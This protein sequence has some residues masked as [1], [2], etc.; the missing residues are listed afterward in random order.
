MSS[1]GIHSLD[2]ENELESNTSSDGNN[3][4]DDR[5]DSSDDGKGSGSFETEDESEAPHEIMTEDKYDDEERPPVS[6]ATETPIFFH[7]DELACLERETLVAE[8]ETEI[9]R[10]EIRL[11]R[12]VGC[13]FASVCIGIAVLIVLYVVNPL[14]ENQP[15]SQAS[16]NLDVSTPTV[17][18]ASPAPAAPTTPPVFPSPAPIIQEPSV[19]LS[20]APTIFSNAITV[21]TTYSA[22]VPFGKENGVTPESMAPDLIAS[23]DLLA[24]QVLL[25]VTASSNQAKRRILAVITVQLPTSIGNLV[26]VGTCLVEQ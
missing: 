3:S 15:K 13:G 18:P 2:S 22:I 14:G 23:M 9:Y 16:S 8:R 1:N 12:W 10:R 26:E 5:E 6:T 21:T 4:N 19:A 11:W 25:E 24:P 7:H 17:A 20:D